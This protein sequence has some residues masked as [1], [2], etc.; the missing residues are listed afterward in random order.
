MI[1]SKLINTVTILT[2]DWFFK[3]NFNWSAFWKLINFFPIFWFSQRWFWMIGLNLS[4]R[5]RF[6]K[7]IF[8]AHHPI[9]KRKSSHNKNEEFVFQNNPRLIKWWK[10]KV[11][12]WIKDKKKLRRIFKKKFFISWRLKIIECYQWDISKSNSMKWVKQE[13]WKICYNY[14]IWIKFNTMITQ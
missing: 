4:S 6:K 10:S 8:G 1:Q 14:L 9:L 2:E 11:L 7:S 3:I 13:T 12:L 5:N